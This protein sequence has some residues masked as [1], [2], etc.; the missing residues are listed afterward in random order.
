MPAFG[1]TAG[2]DE[3]LAALAYI[4]ARWP[5]GLR[6]AQAMLNPD[7]EGLPREAAAGDWSLPTNCLM[8][9]WRNAG[10]PATGPAPSPGNDGR[11]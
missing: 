2:D 10:K 9:A 11:R 8:P 5:I 1:S 7:Q 6:V 4:K 3:I